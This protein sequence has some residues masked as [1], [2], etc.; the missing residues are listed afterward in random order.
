MVFLK[1]TSIAFCVFLL[2]YIGSFGALHWAMGAGYLTADQMLDIA[3]SVF[4]PL[5]WFSESKIW[6]G[7]AMKDF[8]LWCFDL[9][10]G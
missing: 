7:N 3:W 8:Y 1:K 2:C 5:V 10:S 4:R 9:G 6:G